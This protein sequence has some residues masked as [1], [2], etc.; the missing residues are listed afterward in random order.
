MTGREQWKL[1][2]WA[3]RFLGGLAAVGVLALGL[4]YL[5]ER[6]FIGES[7]TAEEIRVIGR[8]LAML[9]AMM[10]ALLL[11]SVPLTRH[12]MR[13]DSWREALS[14]TAASFWQGAKV[15]ALAAA[16]L[17]VLALLAMGLWA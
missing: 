2:R 14:W 3:V 4:R 17:A 13:T 1:L 7:S 8:Q 15:G 12:A 9:L 11:V 6:G 10:L 16:I 5:I